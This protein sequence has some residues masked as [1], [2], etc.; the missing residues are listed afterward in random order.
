MY[1]RI[2]NGPRSF[3]VTTCYEDNTGD[4]YEIKSDYFSL[5][6]DAMIEFFDTGIVPVP[7]EQTIDVIAVRE[8]GFKA[9]ENPFTWIN[10]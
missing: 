5:F 4:I 1:Q 8:A 10:I 3:R 6:I 2:A 9:F 7:H